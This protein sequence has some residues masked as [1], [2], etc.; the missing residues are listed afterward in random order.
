MNKAIFCDLDKTLFDNNRNF[1]PLT[2]ETVNLIQ[3]KGIPFIPSTA[4]AAKNTIEVARQLNVD[5][6]DGYVVSNKGCS[7]YSFKTNSFL[8][9]ITL[10]KEEIKEIFNFTYQKYKTSF[11][12]NNSTYV[13]EYNEVTHK[14]TT[15]TQTNYHIVTNP[16]EITENIKTIVISLEVGLNDKETKTFIKDLQQLWPKLDVVSY[17]KNT[18]FQISCKEI[19]K[20]SVLQFLA[21]H[22]GVDVTNTYAFGDSHNDLELI[23]DAGRGLAV[24]NAIDELKAIADKI[25]LSNQEDGPA[26]YLR[27]HFDI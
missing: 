15:W 25:I 4:R 21:Q 10:T 6:Y 9:D 24:S 19:S 17:Y 27:Q 18:F 26:K 5:K 2:L 22:L 3:A 16:E 13:N 12:S 11:F 23:R 7:I 8:L 20:G 1:S 14:W